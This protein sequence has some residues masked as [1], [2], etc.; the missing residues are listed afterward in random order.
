[1]SGFFY[2][3][4]CLATVL[5]GETAAVALGLELVDVD[6][7][8]ADAEELEGVHGEVLFGLVHEAHHHVVVVAR[9][10]AQP[11][12]EDADLGRVKTKKIISSF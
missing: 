11:D 7:D 9:L 5:L 1:L 4:P 8:G 10:L 3:Q 2:F 12:E 6:G